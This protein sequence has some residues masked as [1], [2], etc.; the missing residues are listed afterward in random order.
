MIFDELYLK[1][2]NN[3]S[4]GIYFV[5]QERQITFWNRA[6]EEITGYKSHDIIGKYCPDNL[7]NHTDLG[8]RSLCVLS[9][10]L[11]STLIDGK[12]RKDNVL[13]RHKNGD[14]IPISINIFPIK[15]GN[16]I[17]GA[18]EIFTP[19]SSI[20][21]ED[22]VIEK[23]SNLAMIDEL[24]QI[25]N[26]RKID[27]YFEYIFHEIAKFQKKF[28]V[29]FL[30]IDDFSVFNNSYGHKIGD[31]VLK[32]I[33][34]TIV[35]SMRK[36]DIFGRW[37]GEEFIGICQ[38]ENNNEAFLIAE[39]IRVLISST[40]VPFQDVSLSV[41]ASIGVTIIR[42]DD[43]IKSLIN[44]ADILMYQSKKKGKNCTTTDFNS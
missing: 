10:P 28:C 42:T 18:V 37:G 19:T 34:Y 35:N 40:K 2:I 21:Y 22:D 25:G 17:I 39:K 29:I 7:L 12:Q 3:I 38:V 26:R 13:L 43:T 20:V 36:N 27:S 16:K 30:D 9:C 5:N 44:R 11:Y 41:T 14:R 23:F 15:E 8:G 6:A 32:K 31:E 33:S 1:I 4:D 24:T